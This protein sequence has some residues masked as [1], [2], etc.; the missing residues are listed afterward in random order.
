MSRISFEA[1]GILG[2]QCS[3]HLFDLLEKALFD[4]NIW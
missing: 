1:K 4:H 2:F 3:K